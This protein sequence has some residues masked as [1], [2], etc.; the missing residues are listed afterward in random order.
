MPTLAGCE[1]ICYADDTLIVVGGKNTKDAID[2]AEIVGNMIARK[3]KWM[4]LQVA[5]N[6]TEAIRFRREGEKR[7]KENRVIMIEDTRIRQQH[8]ILRTNS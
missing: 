7:K 4:G 3:I 5:A 1:I 2:K 6:K 8:K